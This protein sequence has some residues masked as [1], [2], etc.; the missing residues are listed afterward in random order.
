[1][2]IKK[3][4]RSITKLIAGGFMWFFILYFTLSSL[5]TI[6]R[7]VMGVAE[8][9]FWFID[10][11]IIITVIL[12]LTGIIATWAIIK[13]LGSIIW[14]TIITCIIWIILAHLPMSYYDRMTYGIGTPI[15]SGKFLLFAMLFTLILWF[16]WKYMKPQ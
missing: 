7:A 14:R 1:M 8:S 16:R 4:G 6:S 11:P 9:T 12:L 10:Y 2:K 5:F 13:F 15:Y 3:M